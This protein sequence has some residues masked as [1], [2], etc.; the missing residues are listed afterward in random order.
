MA[1]CATTWF[2]LGRP[3]AT[4]PFGPLTTTDPPTGT[5]LRAARTV[6][7]LADVVAA[8]AAAAPVDWEG[9][10]A[11][12]GGADAVDDAALVGAEVVAAADVGSV[13]SVVRAG[14]R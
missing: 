10:E 13:E 6:P 11:P 2:A 3:I 12:V 4:G 7:F 9:L 8:G 1:V 5:E 14:L